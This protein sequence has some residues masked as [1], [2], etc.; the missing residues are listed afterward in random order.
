MRKTTVFQFELRAFQNL[1]LHREIENI[2]VDANSMN[3]FLGMRF[4]DD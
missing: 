2:T 4:L 3:L 1:K